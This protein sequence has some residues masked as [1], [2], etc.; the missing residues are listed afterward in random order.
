[1]KYSI[2][3][4]APSPHPNPL[5]T[6]TKGSW[7]SRPKTNQEVPHKNTNSDR[8]NGMNSTLLV[9]TTILIIDRGEAYMM[10]ENM[11][12]AKPQK[13]FLPLP[14]RAKRETKATAAN[15]AST[16]VRSPKILPF[17]FLGAYMMKSTTY[18]NSIPAPVPLIVDT[19]MLL[20]DTKGRPYQAERRQLS[21]VITYGMP[22]NCSVDLCHMILLKVIIGAKKRNRAVAF[23]KIPNKKCAKSIVLSLFSTKS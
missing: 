12:A 15:T 17:S 21:M 14:C 20:G 23:P 7:P 5:G 11:V 10:M 13:S 19:N 6:A 4:T 2:S 22:E 1:M 9:L 3:C 16:N 8:K 18:M